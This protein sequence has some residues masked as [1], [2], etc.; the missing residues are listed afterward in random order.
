MGAT[1]K[2]LKDLAGKDARGGKFLK[3]VKEGKSKDELSDDVDVEEL[4]GSIAEVDANGD[5]K[6]EIRSVGA[7]PITKPKKQANMNKKFRCKNTF[8]FISSKSTRGCKEL[9]GV[10]TELAKEMVG[11]SESVEGQVTE[12][13]EKTNADNTKTISAKLQASDYAATKEEVETK[14]K[15]W[16]TKEKIADIKNRGKAFEQKWGLKFS[17]EN[18]AGKKT[19]IEEFDEEGRNKLIKS[20]KTKDQK[21]VAPRNK[22]SNSS[23]KNQGHVTSYCRK[24]EEKEKDLLEEQTCDADTDTDAS[25]LCSQFSGADFSEP[26]VDSCELNKDQT[27][28]KFQRKLSLRCSLQFE[29][30]EKAD[31]FITDNGSKLENYAQ[32]KGLKCTRQVREEKD[33]EG[34]VTKKVVAAKKRKDYKPTNAEKKAYSATKKLKFKGKFTETDEK[35]VVEHCED[36]VKKAKDKFCEKMRTKLGADKVKRCE[37]V[38]VKLLLPTIQQE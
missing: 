28:A 6:S 1:K 29:T 24:N 32:S 33:N 35:N 12:C 13:E 7:D 26:S 31:K 16:G 5:V 25:D 38:L 21:K 34:K 8:D 11:D 36:L 23:E 9:E 37:K 20:K 14:L 27:K 15:S 17:N 3:K 30:K 10:A 4:D 18:D 19:K 22:K 2:Q